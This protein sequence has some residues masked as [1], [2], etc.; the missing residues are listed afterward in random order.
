MKKLAIALLAVASPGWAAE[1]WKT[2]SAWVLPSLEAGKA[3]R[4]TWFLFYGEEYSPERCPAPSD[5]ELARLAMPQVVTNPMAYAQYVAGA[6]ESFL[7]VSGT[8]G[9]PIACDD[10]AVG[11]ANVSL[12]DGKWEAVSFQPPVAS[13]PFRELL[14][15][16]Q[17]DLSV[18]GVPAERYFSLLVL[19]VTLGTEHPFGGA[20]LLARQGGEEFHLAAAHEVPALELTPGSW[21]P[22]DEVWLRL[23]AHQTTAVP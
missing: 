16:R 9:Y 20:I 10:G 8:V 6:P 18:S 14:R 5:A 4:E 11:W 2:A 23:Q 12:R 22:A 17:A 1:T 19:P 21:L 13:G 3:A 15:L 7:L